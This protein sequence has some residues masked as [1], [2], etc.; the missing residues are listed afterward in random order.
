MR[1]LEL[2]VP[3]LALWLAVGAAMWLASAFAP[4]LGFE[5][6]ALESQRRGAVLLGQG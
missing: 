1:A 6:P 4:A 5:L 2:R 3:P